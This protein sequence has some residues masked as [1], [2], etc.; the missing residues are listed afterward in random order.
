[1]IDAL[2]HAWTMTLMYAFST[3]SLLLQLFQECGKT[4]NDLICWWGSL[5]TSGLLAEIT[6]HFEYKRSLYYTILIKFTV[7]LD[8]C[9]V[10][11]WVQAQL[12]LRYVAAV[13]A[14]ICGLSFGRYSLIPSL[15]IK[16]SRLRFSML[17]V[18]FLGT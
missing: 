11:L 9:Q 1:M 7:R 16:T 6:D 13:A 17:I 3:I 2:I 8:R 14:P 18:L 12:Y 5:I 4:E 10:F 15:M